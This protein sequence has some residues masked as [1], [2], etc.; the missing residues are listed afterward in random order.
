MSSQTEE[1]ADAVIGFDANLPKMENCGRGCKEIK[2]IL[3]PHRFCFKSKIIYYSKPKFQCW[4]DSA[5]LLHFLR[6]IQD[7]LN[8]GSISSRSLFIIVT[9]DSTFLKTAKD[10]LGAKIKDLK[11]DFY[12]N[13]IVYGGFVIFV[14]L[15]DCKNYGTGRNHDR[16]CIIR[17]VNAFFKKE[18]RP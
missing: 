5:I 11:I 6:T 10:E 8:A 14:R 12:D 15:V 3:C 16:Q 4:S 7:N 2:T 18:S 13:Y 17:T 9:R 1:P